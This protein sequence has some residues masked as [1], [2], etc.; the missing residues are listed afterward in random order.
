MWRADVLNRGRR[1]RDRS[2]RRGEGWEQRGID[3]SS[4]EE[5]N[6]G[7]TQRPF[8]CLTTKVAGS[9]DTG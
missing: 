5:G 9:G 6:G 4:L 7:P 2:S 8:R 1:S 3:A